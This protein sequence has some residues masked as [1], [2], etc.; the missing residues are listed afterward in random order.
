MLKIEFLEEKKILHV[1]TGGFIQRDEGLDILNKLKQTFQSMDTSK[2]Y[3]ILDSGEFKAAFQKDL[4]VLEEI[5]ELYAK[6]P[7]LKKFFIL[8]E[9]ILAKIQAKKLDK[10]NLP[11]DIIEVNSYEEVLSMIK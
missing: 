7:F 5:L 8:P 2:Y 4:D 1:F 3:F 6:T 11:N 10:T 9:N